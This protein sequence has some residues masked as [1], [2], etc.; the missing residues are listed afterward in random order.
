M[1]W[2]QV[3]ALHR[4]GFDIGAHTR[5]HVDLGHAAE[6]EARAEILGA[7]RELEAQLGARVESFAYPYGGRQHLTDSSRMLVK[8]AG[9]RCCCSGYG[10]VNRPRTDPFH[11]RRVPISPWYTSPEQFAL[12]VALGRTD[13]VT[14]AAQITP[15]GSLVP[16]CR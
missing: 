15:S 9:F 2:E 11:L 7:R 4:C 3:R 5:T 13:F 12:Q 1:T 8:E 16:G 10:G 14:R 6:K